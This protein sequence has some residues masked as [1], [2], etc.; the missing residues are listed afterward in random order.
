[1]VFPLGLIAVP[2]GFGMLLGILLAVAT[3]WRTLFGK[4][5]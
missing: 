5:P 1:M 3:A 4:T 2:I